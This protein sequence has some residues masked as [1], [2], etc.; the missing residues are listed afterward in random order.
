[1]YLPLL[2]TF[3]SL[4]DFETNKNQRFDLFHFLILQAINSWIQEKDENGILEFVSTPMYL[5]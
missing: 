4:M 5:H 3:E 2:A 1:M